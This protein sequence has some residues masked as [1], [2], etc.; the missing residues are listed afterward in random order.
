MIAGTFEPVAFAL[1]GVRKDV[2]LIE[3]A[4]ASVG[5]DTGLLQALSALYGAASRAGFGDADMA[6]VHTAFAPGE[7]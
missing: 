4:A 1:D 3:G 6:A 7:S 2:A 5:V